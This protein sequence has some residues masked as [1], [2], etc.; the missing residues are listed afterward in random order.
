MDHTKWTE[1]EAVPRR[2]ESGFPLPPNGHRHSQSKPPRYRRDV[3]ELRVESGGAT[4]A[5]SHSPG[6]RVTVIALHGASE[7]VRDY[8]LYEHLHRTLGRI[9]VGVASFDRR[10]EGASTGD[11]SVGNFELQVSDCLAIAT[12][13]NVRRVGF[14]GF[15]QGAWIAALAASRLRS[16]DCLM[17]VAACG[18]TPYQQMRYGVA[19]H[20][21][22]AG[23]PQDVIDTV[24]RLRVDVATAMRGAPIDEAHLSRRLHEAS[25]ASW[26]PLAYL[27]EELP[28]AAGRAAWVREMD[29]DPAPSFRTVP[30]PALCFYGADDEWLPV[31]T[32]AALWRESALDAEVHVLGGLGHA[33][34]RDGEVDDEYE[35]LLTEWMSARR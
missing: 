22:D 12:A 31:A 35:R 11:P 5:V 32:S 28:D 30:C 14:W 2:Q 8:V 6:D 21:R 33:L 26:W 17:T 15:S 13:L 24:D 29:F 18:V 7:G 34:L 4:L 9:G 20:L 19:R 23:Y 16:L 3:P 27:R 10:G 1:R 25:R